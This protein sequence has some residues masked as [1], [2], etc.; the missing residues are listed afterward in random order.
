[1][2]LLRPGAD[3]AVGRP[4]HCGKRVLL[5]STPGTV[6]FDYEGGE[7]VMELWY[8]EEAGEHSRQSFKIERQLYHEESAYQTIDIFETVGHGRLL[9]IDGI[10]M[11]TE[12]DEFVYHEC[13]THVPMHYLRGPR[14]ALIIGGGDGGTAR[15]LLKY[16][17]LEEVTMVE[18]DEAV[19][20]ACR[21]Y[22]PSVAGSLDDSRLDMRFEDGAAFVESGEDRYDLIVVDSTDPIGPGEVLFSPPFYRACRR[23]L[24]EH[25]VLTAQTE[26]PFDPAY[27]ERIREIYGNLAESFEKLRMYTASIPSYPYALWSFAFASPS[28]DPREEP[29]PE[30]GLP[31]GLR[32]MNRDLA[33]AIFSLPNHVRELLPAKCL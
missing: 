30:G 1:M 33:R 7:D 2:Q 11:L 28:L 5:A 8:T 12:A 16:P 23:R 18:I 25:G 9:V 4:G 13:L 26:S 15:E 32:Y 14:R 19:T 3:R 17:S 20:A 6:R 29:S 27:R 21:E 22:L 10:V 24:N 31:E